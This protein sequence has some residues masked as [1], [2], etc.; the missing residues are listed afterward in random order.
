MKV[1]FPVRRP[2][3]AWLPL[4]LWMAVLFSAST[5]LG[6]SRRTSRILVPLLR[7]LVPGITAPALD[8]IQLG[9]RKTGHAVAYAILASMAWR[10][11]RLDNPSQP[12]TW[13]WAD[14]RFA[15]GFATVYA[16]TDEWHQT[17]TATRQGSVA[18]VALD[19]FGAALG[20]AAVWLWGRWRRQW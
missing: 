12:P 15:L 20:L 17:F 11:R 9:V 10:A 5:D 19:A 1:C 8:T 4:V 7:W 13:S 14:A 16:L 3:L 18:D 6:S 2:L